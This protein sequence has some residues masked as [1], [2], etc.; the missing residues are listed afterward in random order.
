MKE[1]VVD[2]DDDDDEAEEDDEEEEV[3]LPCDADVEAE[4][5]D[6]CENECMSNDDASADND[7]NEE[8]C[9]AAMMNNGAAAIAS[10][11]YS[12]MQSRQMM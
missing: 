3:S 11:R 5:D 6:V 7:S 8:L 2:D 10:T 12:L 9:G 4:W 1:D